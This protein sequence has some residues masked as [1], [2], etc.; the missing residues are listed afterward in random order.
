M[1]LDL[2]ALRKTWPRVRLP[3]TAAAIF[4]ATL[5]VAHAQDFCAKVDRL[6]DQSQ[7]GFSKIAAKP[8]TMSTRPG[9][10]NRSARMRKWI[11]PM[12]AS[13]AAIVSTIGGDKAWLRR[14]GMRILSNRPRQHLHGGLQPGHGGL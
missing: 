12:S 10:G 6:I 3:V 5:G 14:S 9:L 4:S 2:A 13:P 7:S 1:P 11:S 8:A